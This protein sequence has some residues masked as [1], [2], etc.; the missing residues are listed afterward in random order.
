MSGKFSARLRGLWYQFKY[1]YLLRRAIM[2]GP[3]HA[4]AKLEIKGPGKVVFG[5]NVRIMPTAFGG[6]YVS[7]YLNHRESVIRIGNNAVLRGT[8]VGC[9]SS[10]DIGEGAVVESASLFDTDFH[11]IDASRRDA[12][13]EKA[14]KPLILGAGSYVGWECCIGKGVS[15]GDRSVVL[16]RTLLT[17]KTTGPDAIVLGVPGR[18]L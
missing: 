9:E 16:P 10:I 4:H 5:S 8:R 2:Q 18:V 7:L 17:W 12:M 14:V 1:Q 13:D 6:D 11:H 15:L 3:L